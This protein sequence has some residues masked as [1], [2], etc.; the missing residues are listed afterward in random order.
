MV[1]QCTT[2]DPAVTRPESP[3]NA[4]TPAAAARSESPSQLGSGDAANAR[5]PTRDHTPI[6]A[7]MACTTSTPANAR[8]ALG[9]CSSVITDDASWMTASAIAAIKRGPPS[10]DAI[11]QRTTSHDDEGEVARALVRAVPH[12]INSTGSNV[13]AAMIP[14]ATTD[15]PNAT[16]TRSR[17]WRAPARLSALSDTLFTLGARARLRA[18]APA[19]AGAAGPDDGD[20]CCSWPGDC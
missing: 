2:S 12:T 16:R 6:A 3:S 1:D 11:T 15:G 17:A 18:R 8:R 10:A 5:R 7:P 19:Y 9:V 13:A 20:C 4:S 14:S